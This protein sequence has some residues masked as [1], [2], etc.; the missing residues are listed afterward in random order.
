MIKQIVSNQSNLDLLRA[1]S[2]ITIQLINLRYL[3]LL[4]YHLIKIRLYKLIIIITKPIYVIFLFNFKIDTINIL[5]IISYYNFSL[6]LI[7]VYLINI[8]NRTNIWGLANWRYL[9]FYLKYETRCLPVMGSCRYLFSL[10][11]S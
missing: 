8:W 7:P 5:N 10:F 4:W 9:F 1:P 11:R 2:L 6:Q 3:M